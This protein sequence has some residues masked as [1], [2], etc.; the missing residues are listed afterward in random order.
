[1]SKPNRCAL[2]SSPHVVSTSPDG[3]LCEACFAAFAAKTEVLEPGFEDLR[4]HHEC[5]NCTQLDQMTAILK[6][7]LSCPQA[8]PWLARLTM[9]DTNV[10]VWEAATAIVHTGRGE[11]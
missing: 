10:T 3:D 5:Q 9:P 2:C 6:A 1:M 8:A 11:A 4:R 7:I